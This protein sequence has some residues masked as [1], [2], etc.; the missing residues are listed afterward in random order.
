MFTGVCCANLIV[1]IE[2]LPVAGRHFTI[3]N[4]H[5]VRSDT[6]KTVRTFMGTGSLRPAAVP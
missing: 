1:N 6:S 3:F 4:I 2:D 5:E